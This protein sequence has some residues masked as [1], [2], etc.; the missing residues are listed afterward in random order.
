MDAATLPLGAQLWV[1]RTP[2]RPKGMV[3]I[4]PGGGYQWLSPREAEPVARAFQA[5]GWGTAVLSYTV[6]SLPG[7]PPLG[8]LPVR[9]L[10]EALAFLRR[11]A[12]DLPVLVCGFSAGGHLAAT[13][14]VHWRELGL[15]RPDGLILGYPVISAG[16]WAHRGSIE[17]LA[18]RE[19]PSWFSLEQWVTEETP[20]AFCWHTVTDPEVPVQNS[21]LWAQALSAAGVPYELHLYPRGVHGLSL[22]TP[23][24]DEPEKS[25]LA[26]P[27]IAGWFGQCLEWMDILKTTKE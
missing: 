16:P 3:L 8:T 13:L 20:P 18:G 9:Q 27:H 11:Q 22:A 24:V 7:Q 26:D 19:D 6:R 5:G 15:P 23:D 2:I 12:P 1:E 14:G 4:C 21:L 10:G 17:N 25:R